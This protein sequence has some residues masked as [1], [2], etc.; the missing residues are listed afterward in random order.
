MELDDA[1]RQNG[2]KR[3]ASR[4]VHGEADILGNHPV[5]NCVEEHEVELRRWRPKTLLGSG[6]T[7]GGSVTIITVE[8]KRAISD[9][10]PEIRHFF[11]Y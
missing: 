1:K 3:P 8:V 7:L 6:L 4:V 2:G 9:V 11:M 10:V 5:T